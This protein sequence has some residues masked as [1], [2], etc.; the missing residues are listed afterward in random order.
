MYFVYI[1]RSLTSGRY[2][3]GHTQN[4]EQRLQYH[5]AGYSKALKN[6][7]PWELLYTESF[8]SRGQAMKRERQIKSWKDRKLIEELVRASR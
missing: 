1:L 2:Y 3:I 8:A 7:G 5:N 4:V 6:R